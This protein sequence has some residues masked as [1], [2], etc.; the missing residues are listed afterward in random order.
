[1]EEWENV[2]GYIDNDK[3]TQKDCGVDDNRSI[4]PQ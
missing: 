1:M 2:K 4:E 3:I